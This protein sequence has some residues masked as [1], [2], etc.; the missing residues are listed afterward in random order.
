MKKKMHKIKKKR[1]TS[2]FNGLSNQGRLL[3]F[4]GVGAI[5]IGLFLGM[6][7]LHLTKQEV[8]GSYD[9][10]ISAKNVQPTESE[11]TQKIDG[12]HF[13]A[14]QGGVFSEGAN[15]EKQAELF[16]DFNYDTY[17]WVTNEEVYLLVGLATQEMDAKSLANEMTQ[18]GLDV[19]VKKWEIHE[20]QASMSEE[21]AKWLEQFVALWKESLEGFMENGN[22][23]QDKWDKLMNEKVVSTTN[24]ESIH[25]LQQSWEKYSS[26]HATSLLEMIDIYEKGFN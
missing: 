17:N 5:C 3:V 13:F 26:I 2:F 10:P 18:E 12:F 11:N 22:V 25:H 20:Q 19:F 9:K 16:S 24:M 23:P 7:S 8:T 15:A 1:Q 14:V 6:I 21:E 4:T